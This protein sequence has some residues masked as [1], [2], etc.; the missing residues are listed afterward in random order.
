MLFRSSMMFQ[1]ENQNTGVSFK[2]IK[3]VFT[4]A[5]FRFISFD[6]ENFVSYDGSHLNAK[7]AEKLSALVANALKV[8]S[9]DEP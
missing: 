9:I 1:L 2:E 6:D 7:S 8:I 5:G 4:R 3:A